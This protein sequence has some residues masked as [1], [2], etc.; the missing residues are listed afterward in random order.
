[1]AAKRRSKKPEKGKKG[2]QLQ[3]AESIVSS[4]IESLCDWVANGNTLIDYCRANGLSTRTV[5]YHLHQNADA[6][7][8]YARAR[9]IQADHIAV[10]ML[11]LADDCT[12]EDVQSTRTKIDTRK[13]LLSRW[14]RKAY[15]DHQKVEHEG[16][17]NITVVT[18]VPQSS[19]LSR[20]SE[21][22]GR[23]VR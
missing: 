12:E 5:N 8:L 9:E 14:H 19:H 21:E 13:W 18:G 15:G 10:S 3:P 17:M 4:H 20:V 2:G 7:A 16:Q 1:M 22:D 11:Q 23:D 6:A